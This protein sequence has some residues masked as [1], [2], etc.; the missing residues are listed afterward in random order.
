MNIGQAAQAS[1]ISAKMLRYYE[2][3]GLLPAPP[4]SQAGYRFYDSADIEA[5]RFVR[6][7]RD[8]GFPLAAI[9]GLLA[10]WRDS[11]RTSAGVKRMALAQVAALDAKIADMQAMA[12]TLRTLAGACRGDDGPDCAIIDRLAGADAPHL[13]A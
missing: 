5:L 3:V 1:G 2:T 4:R 12:Q 8:L 9:G 13:P 7:A 6:H 10:L 11:G